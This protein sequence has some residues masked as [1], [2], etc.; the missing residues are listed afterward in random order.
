[1]DLKG[2]RDENYRALGGKLGNVLDTI[3][4]LVARGF[5]VEIVTLLVPGFNDD[6]AEI[7]D[8]TRF[9]AAVS[10]SIPWHVTAFHG[11][12]RM[13]DTRDA[14]GDDLRRAAAIGREEGLSF[15]YAGNRPGEV[16]DLED[17]RCASCAATVI[18]RRGYRITGYALDAA[19]RCRCGTALPGVVPPRWTPPAD[20]G[21]LPGRRPRTIA[22]RTSA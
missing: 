14:T 4:G 6:P 5:W 21:G 1:V 13:G 10:P 16:L 2:F 15:V 9:I 19:G 22:M 11:D 17:T 3:Q 7:R 20:E 18:A 8:L 12:Y